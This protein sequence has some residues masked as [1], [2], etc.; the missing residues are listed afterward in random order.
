MLGHWY[1][2][3]L[4]GDAEPPQPPADLPPIRLNSPI[5][6]GVVLDSVVADDD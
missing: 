2:P 3:V 5:A 4:L 6:A 1:I